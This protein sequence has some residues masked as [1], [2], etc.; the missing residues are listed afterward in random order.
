MKTILSLFASASLLFTTSV[1]SVAELN[2]TVTYDEIAFQYCPAEWAKLVEL[3]TGDREGG[4]SLD[5]IEG[6]TGNDA[7]AIDIFYKTKAA[8]D[9]M[10][11]FLS[12][13]SNQI[14]DVEYQNKEFLELLRAYV[15]VLMCLAPTESERNLLEDLATLPDRRFR[16]IA[17]MLDLVDSFD[18]IQVDEMIDTILSME[19]FPFDAE[20]IMSAHIKDKGGC[21]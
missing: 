7:T 9:A 6:E 19:S 14:S 8:A 5:P 13:W 17:F 18:C 16:D 11:T 15:D 4:Y 12:A 10:F 3:R 21:K 2:E 1:A 20:A